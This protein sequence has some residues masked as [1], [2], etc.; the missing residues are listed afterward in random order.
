MGCCVVMSKNAFL[1]KLTKIT[2]I[3]EQLQILYPYYHCVIRNPRNMIIN[4]W[5]SQED[6]IESVN[7]RMCISRDISLNTQHASFPN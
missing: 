3:L 4:L 2:H 5:G 6:Y 1:R 7:L